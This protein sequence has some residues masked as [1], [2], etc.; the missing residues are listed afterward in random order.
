MRYATESYSSPELGALVDAAQKGPVFL[1]RAE[2]SVAV[3]LSAEEYEQLR[4]SANEDFQAFCDEISDRAVAR[5][6]TEE[7]LAELLSRD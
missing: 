3:L 5:G 4:S 6:L 7:K 1:E 2:R